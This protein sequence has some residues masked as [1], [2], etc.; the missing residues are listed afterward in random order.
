MEKEFSW[1]P[2]AVRRQIRMTEAEQ[3]LEDS[4]YLGTNIMN[5]KY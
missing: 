1:T 4:S 5:K 2:V 3:L